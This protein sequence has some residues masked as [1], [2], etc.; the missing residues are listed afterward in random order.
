MKDSRFLQIRYISSSFVSV[1]NS[2]HLAQVFDWSRKVENI[3]MWCSTSFCHTLSCSSRL[4]HRSHF[5]FHLLGTAHPLLPFPPWSNSRFS[6][7]IG[8]TQMTKV[9][10]GSDFFDNGYWSNILLLPLNFPPL[11]PFSWGYICI[12]IYWK[13]ETFYFKNVLIKLAR[14]V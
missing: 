2:S 14:V 7:G 1:Y 5:R 12:C 3:H 8:T 4:T 6:D 9:L 10:S 11:S 13:P